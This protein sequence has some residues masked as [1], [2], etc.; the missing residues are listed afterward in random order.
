MKS[1]WLIIQTVLL[2]LGGWIGYFLGGCDGF[3]IALLVLVTIDY[4]TGVVC[5]I[6]D[7]KL[8]SEIGFKGI[9]KKV[10]I[11]ILVGIAQL[12]D[13]YVFGEAG[14]IRTAV[15]FYYISNEG[16]SII[17]NAAH[18]GIPIP[19]KLK[20]VFMQLH[21]RGSREKDIEVEEKE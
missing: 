5:A 3:L 11:L 1:F 19:D 4:I 16:I 2:G 20:D 9:A 18:L 21:N 15:I 13:K 10:M 7:K 8:S 17:E 14:V 6:Y 12:L